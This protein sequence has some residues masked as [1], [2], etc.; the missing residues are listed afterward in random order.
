MSILK[1][2]SITR[3]FPGRDRP[4]VQDFT[5]ELQENTLLALIGH[6]GSGK[7]T[8]LRM[9]AG[10]EIPDSGKIELAGLTVVDNNI[11]IQPEKRGVGL[12]FQE[13][14]LFPH[15]NVSANIGYGLHQLSKVDRQSR[16]KEMLELTQL[17][18]HE[19]RYPHELSGGEQQRVALARAIAPNPSLLLLDEP[20]SNLDAHLKNSVRDELC[21]IVRSSGIS[22]VLVT[23]D[24][25]DAM[26]VADQIAV[27]F[28][29]KLE[30]LGTP[31]E[32]YE[33]PATRHVANSFE[34]VLYISA[35]T[36]ADVLH[37]QFGDLPQKG[38]TPG[39]ERQVIIRTDALELMREKSANG[40]SLKTKVISTQFYGSK[41]IVVTQ[42]PIESY[43]LGKTFRLNYTE[44]KLPSLGDSV[45]LRLKKNVWHWLLPKEE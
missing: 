35:N 27:L 13:Y 10:L 29:G 32:I 8:L 18:S 37:T 36:G 39:E 26:A 6:S 16:I 3:Q 17:E 22:T 9:I 12:L 33:Q 31:R 25:N 38:I 14:A 40:A 1:I 15:M 41:T 30:Q 24:T 2:Q 7:T 11:F 45:Y 5:L 44:A 4:A 34:N 23:H 19:K 21:N 20:F 42:M 28:N 43:G